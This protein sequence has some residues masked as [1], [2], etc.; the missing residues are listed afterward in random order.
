MKQRKHNS[1]VSNSD[2][3]RIIFA[4]LTRL[5]LPT[6][7]VNILYFQYQNYQ[8]SKENHFQ[9]KIHQ[10]GFDLFFS[11]NIKNISI[12]NLSIS[13][14]FIFPI[15][16]DPDEITTFKLCLKSW[17][18]AFPQA[19]IL[20][21]FNQNGNV[22]FNNFL[23]S[24]SDDENEFKKIV[25]FQKIE[26]DEIGII[27]IDDLFHKIFN[28]IKTDLICLV[29]ND[30]VLPFET[31]DKIFFLS[32]Y[33]LQEKQQFS[34]IGLRCAMRLQLSDTKFNLSQIN[35]Y[36]KS[37]LKD[38]LLRNINVFDNS[39]YS[40][41]F[42]F[43][44]L[45]YNKL[46]IDDIPSFYYGMDR[47]ETWLPGW[48]DDQIPVVSL[49]DECGSYNIGTFHRITFLDKLAENFEIARFHGNK[50]K[51]SSRLKLKIKD[52]HLVNDT[53]IIAVF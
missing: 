14:L 49:G 2:H 11:S 29:K 27:Y 25:P 17:K 41:D 38:D 19:E 28:Y 53:K 31:R 12:T 48:M 30:A 51:I 6:T 18:N 44:S 40:N 8:E 37:F 13:I 22:Y 1:Q 23:N 20:T 16:K 5:F 46:N 21:C 35:Y 7:I 4:F 33:F 10:D 52:R 39:M 15:L 3:Y 32:S 24:L 50:F 42:I 26:T 43:L 45:K 36:F 47:Y 9:G 34:A